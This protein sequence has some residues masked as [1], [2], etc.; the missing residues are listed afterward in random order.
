MVG[1]PGLFVFAAL[2]DGFDRRTFV[3]Y[4][5]HGP[6]GGLGQPL[7]VQTPIGDPGQ[8]TKKGGPIP[9]EA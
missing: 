2:T 8:V 7:S 3:A 5:S 4:G 9:K 6:E 1:L